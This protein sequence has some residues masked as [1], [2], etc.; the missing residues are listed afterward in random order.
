MTGVLG[1]CQFSRVCRANNNEDD[2]FVCVKD[3]LESETGECMFKIFPG[4]DHYCLEGTIREGY[5]VE[6]TSV[7]TGLFKACKSYIQFPE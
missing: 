1:G 2:H 6:A 4:T 5:L 3:K 7:E